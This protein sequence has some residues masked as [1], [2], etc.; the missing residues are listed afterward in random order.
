MGQPPL[1]KLITY[2]KKSY[3]TCLSFPV[4]IVDVQGREKYCSFFQSIELY[5]QRIKEAHHRYEKPFLVEAERLHC[6]DRIQQLR[7]SYFQHYGWE[8]I[9]L[10][11]VYYLSDESKGTLCAYLR[12]RFSSGILY[13]TITLQLLSSGVHS[14]RFL[15]H[16]QKKSYLLSKKKPPTRT[17]LIQQSPV[18]DPTT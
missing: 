16:H 4:G 11:G 2:Q 3:D 10:E 17:Q 8:S 14:L 1:E 6:R 12:K 13:P 7:R 15:F 18:P 5:R 9:K